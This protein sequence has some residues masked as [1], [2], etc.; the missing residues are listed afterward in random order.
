MK[1]RPR[2]PP[3]RNVLFLA[4]YLSAPP[5]SGGPGEWSLL[6]DP[7]GEV[8][9]AFSQDQAACTP[10]TPPGPPPLAPSSGRARSAGQDKVTP[11]FPWIG[12]REAGLS[13]RPGP[14]GSSYSWQLSNSGPH[15]CCRP[16][17]ARS[18][19]EAERSPRVGPGHGE[20][21]AAR[22]GLQH[23]EPVS[24]WRCAAV[25]PA[26]LRRAAA[27]WASAPSSQRPAG[28]SPRA[29]RTAPAARTRP[30][31]RCQQEAG[32]LRAQRAPSS[33]GGRRERDAG[34]GLLCPA[35]ASPPEGQLQRVQ[36][37]DLDPNLPPLPRCGGL[38][39]ELSKPPH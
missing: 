30:A 14:R 29:S 7:R 2:V 27:R 4:T 26:A 11:R 16:G 34:A 24:A 18:A 9:V 31:A 1:L 36:S 20:G 5:G 19:R 33:A 21:E 37:W 35:R 13:P 38:C 15:P 6:R 39:S 12:G 25:R 28:P 22:E 3:V 17:A 8:G 10:R 23:P 32:D